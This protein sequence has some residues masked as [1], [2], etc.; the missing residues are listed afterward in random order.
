MSL[1]HKIV[2][3]YPELTVEEFHPVTGVI[4]LRDDSDGFGPYIAKWDHPTLA[5][6]SDETLGITRNAAN[7]IIEGEVIAEVPAIEAPVVEDSQAG[8]A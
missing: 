3:I 6:P 4:M 5:Q 7:L 8:G 2:E 1:Y